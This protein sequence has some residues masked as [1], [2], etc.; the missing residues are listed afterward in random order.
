[1]ADRKN[2]IDLVSVKLLGGTKDRLQKLG[3]LKQ[4]SPHWLMKDAIEQYLSE[5]EQQEK[6][7]RKTVNRWKEAEQGQVVPNVEVIAWLETWGSAVEQERPAC[8]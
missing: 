4:R 8:R 3:K 2:E 7:K 6:L 1:M 5:E